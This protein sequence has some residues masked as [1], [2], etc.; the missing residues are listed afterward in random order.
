MAEQKVKKRGWVKNAAIIFLAA[1]LVLTF[2]SNTIMNHSLPEVA[3]Q[4]V[5]SGTINAKIRG[6]GTVAANESY[7]VQSE[8]AREVLLTNVARR[9][10]GVRAA[11]G[12]EGYG[13]S[14]LAARVGVR[15]GPRLVGRYVLTEHDVRRGD[16]GRHHPDCIAWTDHAMDRHSP[17]GGCIEDNN[18]PLGIP[19]RCVQTREFDNLLVACRG[20]SF[21]SLAA[22]AVR[23]QRTMM[24]L[25]E[26]AARLVAGAEQVRCE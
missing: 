12:L 5:Q 11:Y 22:S 13:I 2:F 16:W 14:R 24:E 1:M 9:W 7:E 19:L 20:A 25:G 15:E 4:Y 26:A 21:S 23:L 18:G 3:A 8:Q 17:D 10:P 6:T